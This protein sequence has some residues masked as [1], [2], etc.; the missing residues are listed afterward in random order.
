M[1]RPSGMTVALLPTNVSCVVDPLTG[2]TDQS[3][4]GSGGRQ[5]Q[6][7]MSGSPGQQSGGGMANPHQSGSEAMSGSQHGSG[8][9]D[10]KS[11]RDSDGSTKR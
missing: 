4:A 9:A 3:A 1:G 5:Q 11:R 10:Q 8:A 6:S 7:G 2:A